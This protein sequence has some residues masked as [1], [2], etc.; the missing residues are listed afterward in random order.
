MEWFEKEE[1]ISNILN[2]TKA[3]ER[4][5]EFI[6]ELGLPKY[7]MADL[8]YEIESAIQEIIT[9]KLKRR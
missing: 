7:E 8:A 4:L 2:K 5:G 3:Y 6:E 9:S 1:R